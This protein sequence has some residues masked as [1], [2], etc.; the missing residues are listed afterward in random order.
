LALSSDKKVY[1]FVTPL[2]FEI[3]DITR[4]A[5]ASYFCQ[6]LGYQ[7]TATAWSAAAMAAA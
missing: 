5:K 1:K 6:L 4:F 2:K 7:L 3:T